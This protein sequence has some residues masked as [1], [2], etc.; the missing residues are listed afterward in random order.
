MEYSKGEAR[1][2]L[3]DEVTKDLFDRVASEIRS[4]DKE[5]H[6]LLQ[7]E[8]EQIFQASILNARLQQLKEVLMI[9]DQM[10]DEARGE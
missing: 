6:S 3:A 8:K 1:R 2:W 4:M 10:I 7:G 9:P 5:V